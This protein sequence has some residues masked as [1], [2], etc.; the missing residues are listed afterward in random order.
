MNMNE[1][2]AAAMRTSP[3]EDDLSGLEHAAFGFTEW[4]EF[5][6]EV[7]RMRFYKKPMTEEM[8]KHMCEE[9]GDALWYI[10]KACEHLHVPLAQIARENIAKLAARYPEKFSP[11]AAEARADKGGLGH[12]ES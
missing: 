4:G 8:H 7:K 6:S 10:A 5:A 9:V 11:A 2:Q 3:E 1:Y 12:R